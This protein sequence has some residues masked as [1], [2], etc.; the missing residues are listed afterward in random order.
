MEA[1]PAQAQQE[2]HVVRARAELD[3]AY[4]ATTAEGA[5]AHLKLS[6]LH[7]ERARTPLGPVTGPAAVELDWLD[8]WRPVRDRLCPNPATL[9]SAR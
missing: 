3:A 7:P 6:A 1:D 2:W 9:M 8:R 5:A 4:G